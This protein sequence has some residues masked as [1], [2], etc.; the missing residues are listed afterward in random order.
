MLSHSTS[1]VLPQGLLCFSKIS[2]LGQELSFITELYLLVAPDF[3]GIAGCLKRISKKQWFHLGIRRKRFTLSFLAVTCLG[4]FKVN[5][6]R[7]EACGSPWL[8]EEA[9]SCPCWRGR[10]RGYRHGVPGVSGEHGSGQV[11]ENPGGCQ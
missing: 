1:L 9:E 3:C 7:H 6:V 2:V 10:S 4:G 11:C 5:G 8:R